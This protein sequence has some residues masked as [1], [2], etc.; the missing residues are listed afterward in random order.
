MSRNRAF[1]ILAAMTFSICAFEAMV[2]GYGQFFLWPESPLW[3][4]RSVPI[5]G[6]LSVALFA[7][8]VVDV[9]RQENIRVPLSKGLMAMV[10]V[11]F[12]LAL[13]AAADHIYLAELVGAYSRLIFAAMVIV[14]AIILMRQG[15]PTRRLLLIVGLF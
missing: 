4:Y 2:R 1:V 3:R 6:H 12:G 14:C 9:A 10:A 5:L 15:A 11:H 7:W 8:F 13:L